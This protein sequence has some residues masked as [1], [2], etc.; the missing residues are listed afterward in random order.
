MIDGFCYFFRDKRFSKNVQNPSGPQAGL[1]RPKIG[2]ALNV[3][4]KRQNKVSYLHKGYGV[5]SANLI[6]QNTILGALMGLQTEIFTISGIS[7]PKQ[8]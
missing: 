5:F 1:G 3:A 8:G 6:D 4:Q 7:G 2:L